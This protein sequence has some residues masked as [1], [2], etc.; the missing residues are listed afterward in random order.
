MPE[1][2]VVVV[3]AGPAGSSASLLL[4]RAGRRVLLVERVRFPRWKVCG[5]CVGPA[6][7][8]ILQRLGV[9]DLVEGAGATPIRTMTLCAGGARTRIA[10]RGTVALSRAA[11]DQSLVN[12]A[13]G[14]GAD[15]WFDTRVLA[16]EPTASG[17]DVVVRA[18]GDMSA[19]LAPVDA[20]RGGRLGTRAHGDGGGRRVVS[21]RVVVDATGLGVG[22]PHSGT[23]GA[24]RIHDHS[25]VGIG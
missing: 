22:L 15:V 18:G 8:G 3:G 23:R 20:Y 24:E 14:A 12:A 1:Y 5:A 9:H 13:V 6:A 25:R 7:L 21:A 2:D 10:L 17:I 11:L 19:E 16:L 4:A